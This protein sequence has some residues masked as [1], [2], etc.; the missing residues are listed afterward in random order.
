MQLPQAG[1]EQAFQA[2]VIDR[3]RRWTSAKGAFAEPVAEHALARVLAGLRLLPT[4]ARARTWGQPAGESLFGQPVT[5]VGSGGIATVL[6]RLLE[7]FRA[8]VTVVRRHAGAQPLAGAART[9]G[10]DR[11][12]EALAGASSPSTRPQAQPA[13]A[14]PEG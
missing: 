7:P 9:V 12:P 6:L 1:T 13:M 14:W 2:G 4:R 11:L 5:V 8:Q 10:P 3:Q